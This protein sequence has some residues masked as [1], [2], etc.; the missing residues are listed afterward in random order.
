[1]V[2]PVK[3]SILFCLCLTPTAA[4]GYEATAPQSPETET[5]PP[6]PKLQ[7]VESEYSPNVEPSVPWVKP[8][9]QEAS[10]APSSGSKPSS[11]KPS[12]SKSSGK[13]CSAWG[14]NYESCTPKG[15][16]E[17]CYAKC[18]EGQTRN[19]ETCGCA[20]SNQ[21][22]QPAVSGSSGE[23]QGREGPGAPAAKAG[24]AKCSGSGGICGDTAREKRVGEKLKQ[25]QQG[26]NPGDAAAQP[27]SSPSN[28]SS[29]KAELGEIRSYSPSSLKAGAQGAA[30]LLQ[31]A[32][33]SYASAQASLPSSW[34]SI[35]DQTLTSIQEPSIRQSALAVRKTIDA[36]ISAVQSA[37]SRLLASGRSMSSLGSQA[38]KALLDAVDRSRSADQSMTGAG[39][40]LKT[41]ITQAIGVNAQYASL[42]SSWQGCSASP[43]AQACRSP[44]VQSASSAKQGLRPEEAAKAASG[45]ASEA[46]S[47]RASLS[48]EESLRSRAESAAAAFD[49]ASTASRQAIAAL[50]SARE[51]NFLPGDPNAA[52]RRGALSSI[53]SS[54]CSIY[55]RLDGRNPSPCPASEG[56]RE[57]A[58]DPGMKS[59]RE[60]EKRLLGLLDPPR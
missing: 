54:A 18:Y 47:A 36:R 33:S 4:F 6:E 26:L 32:E 24:P 19:Q 60:N 56:I 14:S 27:P 28:P 50:I 41:Q 43:M 10:P 45:A 49:S 16:K 22:Q 53:V 3:R 7:R 34:I 51:Q 42:A 11:S 21:A 48:G 17:G 55:A 38:A 40:L 1:M 44:L 52:R 29:L 58:F 2:S 31:N 25:Y 5:A 37:L 20:S 30:D 23:E 35:V 39:A 8:L 13:G 59:L 9:S 15:G 57:S 12:S 46:D